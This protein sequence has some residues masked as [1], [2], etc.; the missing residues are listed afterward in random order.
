MSTKPRY[1]VRQQSSGRTASVTFYVFDTK[2]QGRVTVHPHRSREAAQADADSLNVTDM[3]KPHEEDPRPYAV[4]H[5]EAEARYH[6]RE[7]Q[8]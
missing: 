8:A 5:A 1:T 2:R 4:R 6:G 7:A 3:V